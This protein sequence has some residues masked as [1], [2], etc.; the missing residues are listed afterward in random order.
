MSRTTRRMV[1]V[2]IT[3]VAT[4]GLAVA[5]SG[6]TSAYFSDTNSG[7]V[8]GT[9]GFVQVQTGGGGGGDNLDLNFVNLMPGEPQSRTFDYK[10]IGSGPQDIWITFPSQQALHALNNL[11]Q[12][13]SFTITDSST[14]VVFTSS[15]LNDNRP[16][17]SGGCGPFDPSGCWPM[18][19]AYKVRSNLP[20]GGEGTVTLTFSYSSA[21]SLK[22]PPAGL[23]GTGLYYGNQLNWNYYPIPGSTGGDAGGPVSN[24][25]PYNVVATQV[26]QTP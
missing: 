7:K 5:A 12:Y 21:Y 8:T 18:L 4:V 11:G 10:N 2:G 23:D 15:N 6:V 17:A 24:G 14:G 3:L 22:P 26:G 20:V 13:G 25:L 19:N 16:P 1:G 9:V